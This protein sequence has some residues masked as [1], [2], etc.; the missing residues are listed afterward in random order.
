MK[1]YIAM[2]LIFVFLC[3]SCSIVAYGGNEYPILPINDIISSQS[4]PSE[5]D[6]S[7]EQGSSSEPSSTS[8]AEDDSS[9]PEVNSDYV[10][11]DVPLDNTTTTATTTTT[12]TTTIKKTTAAVSIKK[13]SVTNIKNK[14]YTGKALKQSPVVKYKGTALKK[15][16]DYTVTYKNNK[17]VGTA[18]VIIK[19]KGNYTGTVKKTFKINHK[20]TSLKKL[21]NPKSKQ[22][23]VLWKAQK[24]QTTGYQIQYSTSASFKKSATKT[25]YIKSNK[26]TSTVIKKLKKNKKYYVRIRTYKKVSGKKYYSSWSKAKTI[27]ITK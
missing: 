22:I 18:T 27:K 24:T 20:K 1:K 7:S 9:L 19:G 23:K 5:E 21:T 15:G 2:I 4:N 12:T 10:T 6:A 17:K 16:R 13:C 3:M 11:P 25:L 26:K 8:K 14:T